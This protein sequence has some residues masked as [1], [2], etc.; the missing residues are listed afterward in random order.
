LRE[1]GILSL[2]VLDDGLGVDAAADSNGTHVGIANIR[3]RLLA[4]YGEHASFALQPN[5]PSGMIARLRIP[6]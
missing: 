6:L 5:T 2:S 3:E 4:L 1:N